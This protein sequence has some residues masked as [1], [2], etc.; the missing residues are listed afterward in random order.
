MYWA[1]Y[2]I[3]IDMK[4]QDDAQMGRTTQED[5]TNPPDYL[6]RLSQL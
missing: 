1:Q 5:V 3:E 2:I 6:L 4:N